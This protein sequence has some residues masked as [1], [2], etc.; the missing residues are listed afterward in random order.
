MVIQ[1]GAF[2]IDATRRLVRR[3]TVAIHLTPKAF[4]L[5]HVLVSEA[6]RVVSKRELHDRL[7]PGTFVSDAS[8]TGLVKELR[9]ALRDETQ[10]TPVIRTV[11]RVGY[12][13]DLEVHTVGRREGA[14]HWLV[15][16]EHRVRLHQKQTVIGRDPGSDVWLDVPGVSRRHARIVIEPAG[17]RLEDLDSK[18]G[19]T[20]G[21]ARIRTSV[22]LHDGDRIAF[23]SVVGVYRTSSA[24][25]STQ[26]RGRN[27]TG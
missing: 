10:E 4:D 14:G 15:F 7:W 27:A 13:C 24:E 18:N 8:L 25:M 16:R 12:A 19:T 3:G 26:T 22:T 1:L 2:S 17:V 21:D 23:G 11:H 6:P 5:L 20:V 9:R